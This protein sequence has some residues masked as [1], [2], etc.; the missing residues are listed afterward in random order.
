LDSDISPDPKSLTCEGGVSRTHNR[1]IHK[2]LN[3]IA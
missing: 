1:L 2:T 3:L